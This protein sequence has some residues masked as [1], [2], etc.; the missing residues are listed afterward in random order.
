M[1]NKKDFIGGLVWLV[2][3]AAIMVGSLL[4]LEVGTANEPGPGLLPLIAGIVV[5]LLAL[6]VLLKS[7]LVK[8]QKEWNLRNSWQRSTG[9]K[10]FYTAGSLLIYAAMLERVGFLLMTLLLLLFLFRK[11]EPQRW[12]VAMALSVVA[13]MGSYLVFDRLLQAQLPRG[14]FGF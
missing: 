5:S 9:M 7:I 11:I 10:L 3:G 14:I 2:T 8:T 12:K 6:V 13:S 1:M 4:S